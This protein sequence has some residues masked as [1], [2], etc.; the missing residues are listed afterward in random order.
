MIGWRG[1][2]SRTNAANFAPI[3]SHVKKVAAEFGRTFRG[4]SALIDGAVVFM[5]CLRANPVPP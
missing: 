1:F 3:R 5:P 2:R 4:G